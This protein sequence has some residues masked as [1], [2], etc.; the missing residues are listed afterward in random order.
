MPPRKRGA[1]ASK[2]AAGG[3]RAKKAAKQDADAATA[4]ATVHDAMQKLKESDKNKVRKHKPDAMCPMADQCTVSVC[5]HTNFIN[6]KFLPLG[7]FLL[8][9]FKY[10]VIY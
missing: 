9:Q 2:A 10:F 7:I 5:L 8:I 6:K 1:A 3:K 4:P